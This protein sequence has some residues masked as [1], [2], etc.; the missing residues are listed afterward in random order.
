[1]IKRSTAA[2]NNG[3]SSSTSTLSSNNIIDSTT[4]TTNHKNNNDNNN[5]NNYSKNKRIRRIRRKPKM[6]QSTT[7]ITNFSYLILGMISTFILI[8]MINSYH[9][10]ST[11]SSSNIDDDNQ[12]NHAHAAHYKDHGYGQEENEE[13]QQQQH[14]QQKRGRLIGRKSERQQYQQQERH[15]QHYNH[16]SK[17]KTKYNDLDSENDPLPFEKNGSGIFHS[18]FQNKRKKIMYKHSDWLYHI[19]DHS[20]AYSELRKE[21]DTLLPM[22]DSSNRME[23]YVKKLKKHT[24]HTLME[25]EM[26]YD[27]HNCPEYPPLNYPHQWKV[28][29]VLDNW[30]PDDTNTIRTNIY[31]GL[32]VFNYQTEKYK[33]MN[34]RK[35]EVPFIVQNDPKVMRTVERWNQPDYLQK[36]LGNIHHRTEFSHN[37]HFMYWQKP[38]RRNIEKGIVPEDWKPPTKMIRM[39]FDEWLRHA[40]VTDERLLDP[41]HDHWYYRLIGCGEMGDCD[42]GSSEYLF[43]ELPFFQPTEENDL[44]MVQPKKQKGI[45]CRFG[46]RGVIAENHFDGSRCV[47]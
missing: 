20:V 35:A 36:L 6:K 23:Q 30:P 14:P 42:N 12:Y 10:S 27:I 8:F 31:Q 4:T 22:E 16:N 7:I 5:N 21:Y 37:N 18:F 29:D 3:I 44:Y 11:I 39:P 15:H 24:Y 38:S 1:M 28:K 41:D 43:D 17:R 33:A 47:S 9:N 25:H 46:M 32:C 2:T 40:N 19:G 34:Y 13:Q 26:S 45:H